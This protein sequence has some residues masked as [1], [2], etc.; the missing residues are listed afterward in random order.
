MLYQSKYQIVFAVVLVTMFC[1]CGC[2]SIEPK[3]QD[4]DVIIKS[5][6]IYNQANSGLPSNDI[7]ALAVDNFGRVWIGTYSQGLAKLDE[8]KCTIYNTSNSGLPSNSIQCIETDSNNNVWIGT[9]N[10][11]A[12]FTGN[13][14]TIYSTNN[15]ALLYSVIR[16]LAVDNK[17]LLWIGNGHFTGGGLLSFDGRNW[18][19]YTKENSTLPS[20]IINDIYIDKSNNKWI[21]TAGGLVNIDKQNTITT[22]TKNNSGLLFGINTVV[23]DIDNGVWIGA[24]ELERLDYEHYYGGLQKFDGKNW[25]DFRPHPNGVYNPEAITSNRVDHIISD[26]FGYLLIATEAEWRY[27]YNLSFFKN[28][29]W[30]NLSDIANGIP[31]NLFI[32]DMKIDKNG[33]LW[34]ATQYGVISI[35]YAYNK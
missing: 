3:T 19:V 17:G 10:G 24:N 2:G 25:I 18:A 15:S 7:S 9:S 14:W 30:K 23:N 32:R 4:I 21:G 35:N 33:I 6:A 11:L 16:C 34:L 28:G 8:N 20:N 27:P 29:V 26:R 1:G 13:S 12:K 31:N 5:W 22:F